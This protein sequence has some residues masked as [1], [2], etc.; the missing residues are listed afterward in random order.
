MK[1]VFSLTAG[2]L[3][4]L[5]GQAQTGGKITGMI[6]DGDNPKVIEAATI[7]LLNAKDSSLVKATYSEKNGVFLFEGVK[8]G[9]YLV[10]A[11]SIGHNKSWSKPIAIAATTEIN[12]GTLQLVAADKS[13]KGVTVVARKSLIE[14]RADKTIVNVE[15]NVNNAGSTALEV[16]EKSPGISIDKD[17]NIGLKGKQ[18]VKILI[19]GKQSYLS[20]ADLANLLKNM[21]ASQLDQIEIMTNPPAKYDAAGNAG[22]INIRLKKTKVA[23][24]NGSI[25]SSYSQG[26]HYRANQSVNFNYRKQQVNI[27]GN[28]SYRNERS[29]Q[30]LVIQRKFRD[31]NTRELLSIFDQEANIRTR[32]QGIDARLG[33]DY[34]FSKRT[35]VGLLVSGFSNPDK[36]R[37]K[38]STWLRDNNG[39]ANAQ[40]F[41]TTNM[42]INWRNFSGNLNLRH[43]LD[44]AGQEITA[45]I[46]YVNYRSSNQQALSNYFFDA[47]GSKIAPSDTLLGQLP[48]DITIYSA[49]TDY[50]RPLGHHAKLEAGLKWSS[51]KT[52]NNV[53]YDSLRNNIRVAD[54]N[55]SNHFVYEEQIQAAYVSFSKPIDQKWDFQVGLR[56]ENTVSKGRQ[57]TTGEAFNRNYT[58]LFPT[59]YLGYKMNAANNFSL[60]YG[61][62]IERPDY[63]DLNPFYFFLDRYT[64][65]TGNPLLRP[66]FAHNAELSH[67][68]KNILTTTINYYKA[69]DLIESTFE[70]NEVKQETYVKKNNIASQEQLGLAINLALPVQKWLSINLYSNLNHNRYK[71]VLNNTQVDLRNTFLMSNLTA[72]MNFGK[73][74]K[75]SVDGFYRT[76]SVEGILVISGMG[77]MNAGVSKSVLQNKGTLKLSVRDIFW[78]QRFTG[79]AQYAYIDTRFRQERDSRL[80]T[81]S[82]TYRFGKGKPA[83]AR[84]QIGGANDEK[85]RVKS[86][87]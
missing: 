69:T 52:D 18:G 82:F 55:R 41:S 28:I 83:S 14:H 87:N 17:G 30:D 79:T 42:D 66:Q 35:T 72:Q 26:Q 59:A 46:D 40:T 7:S 49:K 75:A 50:T 37:N 33:V 45:D 4:A 77:A 24:F 64:Y 36:F 85:G 67:S 34:N 60:N 73:G 53:Q 23:G 39:V 47:V 31:K 56:L 20:G 21:P 10:M 81:L 13:L 76:K 2:L 44:S 86:G 71:G 54:N 25:T 63:A 62:R 48:A 58:Q 9:K 29:F 57:L 8:P 38:N 43:V 5:A 11:S 1:N 61:R 84:R 3:L 68:Y 51:V 27:F 70:Q 6:K 12:V 80:L 78:S 19:D 15:A 74:W 65:E 22:V 32:R 16:L